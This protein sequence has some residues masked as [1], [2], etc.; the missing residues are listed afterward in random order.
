MT[1]YKPEGFQNSHTGVPKETPLIDR[2]KEMDL[3]KEAAD[4]AISDQGEL[5]FLY[6]EAGIGKTRLTKELSV[7]ARS[8]GMQIL[9][10]R[11]PALFKMNGVP[12]YS[13]WKEV[14]KDYLQV[15]HARAVAESRWLLPGR[16]L[17]NSPRD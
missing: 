3:L 1:T 17:Q 11:C 4:K 13:P 12:P 8:R 14:I 10:G 2:A 7:Y 16:N 9:Y 6:G 5:F 15:K